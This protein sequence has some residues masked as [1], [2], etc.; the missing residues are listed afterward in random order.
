VTITS[1]GS[2]LGCFSEDTAEWR[3]SRRWDSV[4]NPELTPNTRIDPERENEAGTC[5]SGSL[6]LARPRKSRY[7]RMN[8][9]PNIGK[10]LGTLY[11]RLQPGTGRPSILPFLPRPVNWLLL[12]LLLLNSKSL[13]FAWLPS[14]TRVLSPSRVLVRVF[15]IF[16]GFELR[17]WFTRRGIR[18][19]CSTRGAHC[20][21]TREQKSV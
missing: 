1:M 4:V 10:I 12:G 14:L 6:P 3:S 18:R 17:G 20:Y 5:S 16:F 21:A 11:L 19:R 7:R 2:Q 15:K 8:P 9:R 13:P